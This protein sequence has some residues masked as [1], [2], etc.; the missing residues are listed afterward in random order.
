MACERKIGGRQVSSMVG[1]CGALPLPS[2]VRTQSAWFYYVCTV[3]AGF[4]VGIFVCEFGGGAVFQEYA[5][6]P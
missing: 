1:N 3:S 5:L 6:H 2:P 4:A